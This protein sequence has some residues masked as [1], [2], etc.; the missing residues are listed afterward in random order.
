[1][2][3]NQTLCIPGSE[4]AKC[5]VQENPSMDDGTR[6]KFK[7]KLVA[8]F[9]RLTDDERTAGLENPWMTRNGGIVAAHA[10]D[11]QA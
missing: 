6:V 7:F 5:F 11:Q 8:S 2:D 3:Y 1:M 4:F 9:G 10:P